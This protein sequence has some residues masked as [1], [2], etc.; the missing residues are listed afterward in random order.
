MASRSLTA[1]VALV[2]AIA[3]ASLNSANAG[4]LYTI[5]GYLDRAPNDAEVIG[6]LEVS[7]SGTPTR[8][9]LVTACRS[10]T[11][12]CVDLATSRAPLLVGKP[13]EVSRLLGAPPGVAVKLTF[14]IYEVSSLLMVELGDNGA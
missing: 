2:A 4:D 10:S 14:A 11:L 9:L 3:A 6:R 1:L 8:Y 5:E 13:E 7:S 12:A